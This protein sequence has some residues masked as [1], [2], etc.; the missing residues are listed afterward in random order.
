MRYFKYQDPSGE[1]ILSEDEIL[2]AYYLYWSNQMI[3]VNKLPMVTEQH[4]LDDWITVYWAWEVA[5][6]TL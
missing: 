3:K 4:C 6:P 5:Q 2:D 1:E